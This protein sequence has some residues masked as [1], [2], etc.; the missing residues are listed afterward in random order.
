MS[1]LTFSPDGNT[2]ATGNKQGEI[3]LWEADTGKEIR[4]TTLSDNL[5]M[6]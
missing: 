5:Q 2:Y 3:I 6:P 4:R 1:C